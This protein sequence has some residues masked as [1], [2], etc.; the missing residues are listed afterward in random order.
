M[1]Y[2]I[3][4]QICMFL[5]QLFSPIL[6]NR[7]YFKVITRTYNQNSTTVELIGHYTYEKDSFSIE[8][9]NPALL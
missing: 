6:A 8:E 9:S 2:F 5:F 7:E 3:S 1:I 4:N